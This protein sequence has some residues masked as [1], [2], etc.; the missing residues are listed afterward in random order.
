[1]A[2]VVRSDAAKRAAFAERLKKYRHDPIGFCRDV[3]DMEPHD[4]QKRW[5]EQS[6]LGE[7]ALTTGNRWGKS[8]IAA[9]K[10]I[11][12]C[13]Y[14]LGWDAEIKA[15][16]ARKHAPYRGINVSLT[17]DQAGLVWRKAYGMLQGP[18]AGWLIRDTRM[19]PFPTFEFVNG[20][21]F[22]ARSTARDGVHLL[23][24]DYDFVNWDEAAYEPKFETIRDNVLRMRLVDRRGALDYT[25]TGN[26]RNDY[27][28]YF[29]DALA[30]KLPAVYAQTGPTYENPNIPRDAVEANA[31]RMSDQKRRQN[32]LGEVVD[33]GGGFFEAADIAEFWDTELSDQIE[34]VSRDEEEIPTRIRLMLEGRSWETRYPSHRYVHGWDLANRKDWATGFTIDTTSLTDAAGRPK[35]MPV[36]EYERFHKQGWKHVYARIR[37]RHRRF[38]GEAHSTTVVDSTGV[39]DTVVEELEDIKAEGYWFTNPAKDD[40]LTTLQS[41]LNLR[42]ISSPFIGQVNDELSFYDRD[43]ENLIKD[44]VMGLGLATLYA[45]RHKSDPPLLFTSMS[46][47]RR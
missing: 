12:K 9:A 23:G 28:R 2:N 7:N 6:T 31:A 22:E 30:G 10:M 39:G 33:A 24:N 15:A 1:M 29:L 26:G 13:V 46:S 4:G 19:T 37:D 35:R 34:I 11:W 45:K 14:R 5:L 21:T 36:V 16:M 43:D 25:S 47:R 17:A 42:E 40:L 27:G 44:C 41:A 8:H 20:A 32:I 18:K 3:L 38:G